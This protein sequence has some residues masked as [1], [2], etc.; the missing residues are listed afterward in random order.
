MVAEV[1]DEDHD[2]GHRD[3]QFDG[4]ANRNNSGEEVE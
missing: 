2:I 1:D 4:T 3:D